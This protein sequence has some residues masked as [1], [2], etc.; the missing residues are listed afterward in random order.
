MR[1]GFL[2]MD[3][4]DAADPIGGLVR[5]GL[6]RV[7]PPTTDVAPSYGVGR[8]FSG[9]PKPQLR[10]PATW[11]SDTSGTIAARFVPLTGSPMPAEN[12]LVALANLGRILYL[13]GS[14]LNRLAL[15]IGGGTASE[16]NV[17]RS[18]AAGDVLTGVARWT[19]T[20]QDLIFCG[21]AAQV[22]RTGTNGPGTD[23]R[24]GVYGSTSSYVGPVIISPTRFSDADAALLGASP[25]DPLWSDIMR[26]ADWLRRKYPGSLLLPLQ[27]DSVS[28]LVL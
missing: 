21:T 27:S 22:A 19:A 23:I 13:G 16:V 20:T 26:L 9:S 7:V 10:I 1:L 18:W 15:Y 24:F 4:M 5:A 12:D 25:A 6:A 11:L 3:L 2:D 14:G 8:L 17:A 28:Y